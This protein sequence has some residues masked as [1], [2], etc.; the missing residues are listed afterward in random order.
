MYLGGNS[1]VYSVMYMLLMAMYLQG[2]FNQV[3]YWPTYTWS[4]MHV[5]L[6][7]LFIAIWKDIEFGGVEYAFPSAEDYQEPEVEEPEDLEQPE[8]ESLEDFAAR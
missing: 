3:V 1:L 8:G 6:A 7:G 4:F 2:F 5:V